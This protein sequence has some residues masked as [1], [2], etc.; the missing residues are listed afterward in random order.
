VRISHKVKLTGL[1]ADFGISRNADAPDDTSNVVYL[2]RVETRPLD[3][4][5]TVVTDNLSGNLTDAATL[6]LEEPR[7]QNFADIKG[8]LSLTLKIAGGYGTEVPNFAKDES[9]TTLTELKTALENNFAGQYALL[10]RESN[11]T[12]DIF[13]GLKWDGSN[14]VA[15]DATIDNAG[16][17]AKKEFM[18]NDISTYV[19][20][21]PD[22]DN[23]NYL[24]DIE[25]QAQALVGE[26]GTS[27]QYQQ[28][29]DFLA[30][31]IGIKT[32]P[33][34]S[35]ET[36]LTYAVTTVDKYNPAN[37]DSPSSTERSVEINLNVS[38]RADVFP[39]TF[40]GSLSST[41]ENVA[42]DTGVILIET[43]G[44]VYQGMTSDG[45]AA[46][47]SDFDGWIIGIKNPDGTNAFP[48]T[49]NEIMLQVGDELY[50]AKPSSDNSELVFNI[51]SSNLYD[52]TNDYPIKLVTPDFFDSPLD[53]T[54]KTLS[55][56]G[57]GDVAIS[58]AIERSVDI[59]SVA[60]GVKE[61]EDPGNIVGVEDGP[62]D[63][64]IS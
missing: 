41:A 3:K 57:A 36:S 51:P 32:S 30:R 21:S 11:A 17:W 61:L 4:F 39:V 49:Y 43:D 23:V 55:Q 24:I 50:N 35:G 6:D 31:N 60:D 45:N 8:S 54:F 13:Y 34:V 63:E 47:T 12:G 7:L 53:L 20:R 48:K 1:N 40:T 9:I 25:G 62:G 18:E 56:G 26:G 64:V 19:T 29:E 42:S 46:T 27:D 2:T 5:T 15:D 10:L 14:L 22:G 52:G 33:D 28:A 16:H 59:Y 38:G 44:G 37:P 58:S